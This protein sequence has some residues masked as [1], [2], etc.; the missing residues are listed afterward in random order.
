MGPGRALPLT[1]LICDDHRLFADSI[2]LALKSH[3]ID[4]VAVTNSAA[5]ALEILEHQQVD[6]CLIDRNLPDGDGLELVRSITQA[7]PGARVLV[8][9]GS[10]EPELAGAA[11]DAGA[12]GF[13]SKELGVQHL[14]RAVRRVHAG[15]TVEEPGSTARLRQN[16]FNEVARLITSR[17]LAVLERLVEGKE[18]AVIATELGISYATARTHIQ[19]LLRKLDVHSKLGLVALAVEHRLVPP[20]RRTSAGGG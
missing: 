11:L 20:P 18:T 4:V 16:R 15:D 17:E 10:T 12:A 7:H 2:A 19:N 13:A 1:A 8:V 3:D 9:S 6:V 5:E 14:A